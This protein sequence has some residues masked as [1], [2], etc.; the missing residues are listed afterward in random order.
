MM[1]KMLALRDLVL[2]KAPSRQHLLSHPPLPMTPRA[3]ADWERQRLVSWVPSLEDSS[4]SAI[5]KQ[6]VFLSH[7]IS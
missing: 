2:A 7:L 3:T 1:M 6:T 5:F 4:N